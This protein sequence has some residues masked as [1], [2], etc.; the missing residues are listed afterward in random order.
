MIGPHAQSKIY[1]STGYTDMRKGIHSLSLLVYSLLSKKRTKDAVVVFRGRNAS[2]VKILWWDGQGFCLFYKCFDSGK[3]VWPS[4]GENGTVGITR[5][6]L[7]MLL[8]G[9]DWRAPSW[10]SAPKYIA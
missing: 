9:I 10:S 7:S 3:I 5:A 8:E 4:T 1:L 2:R 6:Q